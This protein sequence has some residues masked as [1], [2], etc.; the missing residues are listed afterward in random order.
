MEKLTHFQPTY[1]PYKI[2]FQEESNLLIAVPFSIPT[3]ADNK[4][5]YIIY[6]YLF[7]NN[8]WKKYD[9]EPP[10]QFDKQRGIYPIAIN[11]GYIYANTQKHEIAMITLIE[12]TN[13]YRIN[14]IRKCMKLRYAYRTIIVK[15]NITIYPVSIKFNLKTQE[16]VKLALQKTKF[17]QPI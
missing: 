12:E 14:I 1:F 15:M 10:K 7:Y 16:Y 2:L 9:I 5:Q 11:K 3:D 13:K 4:N 8:S 6:K 17:I